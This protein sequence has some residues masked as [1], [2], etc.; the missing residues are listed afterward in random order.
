[1]QN[2]TIEDC[3]HIHPLRGESFSVL[4][5]YLTLRHVPMSFICDITTHLKANRGKIYN[6]PKSNLKCPVYIHLRESEIFCVQQLNLSSSAFFNE[7]EGA[8][9]TE[10]FYV[11]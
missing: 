8:I 7:G 9:S 2:L 10:Y 11:S 1:M 6:F 3:F 4:T 5:L